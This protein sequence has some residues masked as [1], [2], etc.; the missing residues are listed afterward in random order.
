MQRTVVVHTVSGEKRMGLGH[1]VQL[2]DSKR[3]IA[4][5]R[6]C[7]RELVGLV[8]TMTTVRDN[9][10]NRINLLEKYLHLRR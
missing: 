9:H 2:V 8:S 5:F 7:L 1:A 3:M 4:R 6:G 10:L